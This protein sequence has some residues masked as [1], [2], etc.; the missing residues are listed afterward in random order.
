M[1]LD[2][3]KLGARAG[4]AQ[5]NL[6]RNGPVAAVGHICRLG[7]GL[8]N[9][10]GGAAAELVEDVAPG[11][12]WLARELMGNPHHP[13]PLTKRRHRAAGGIA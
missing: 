2:Q 13:T 8:A 9:E 7:R 10:I 11:A 3:S 5:L 6:N 1:S 4:I 12:E